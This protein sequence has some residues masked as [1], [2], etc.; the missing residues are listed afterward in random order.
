MKSWK[1]RLLTFGF[2]AGVAF[3]SFA[4]APQLTVLADDVKLEDENTSRWDG[5][6]TIL[7]DGTVRLESYTGKEGEVTIPTKLTLD[8]K[9]YKVV[10]LGAYC[11]NNN[12]TVT[13][14]FI[15]NGIVFSDTGVANGKTVTGGTNCFLGASNLS[16]M[17]LP[18]DMKQNLYEAG[19]GHSIITP[20]LK[21]YIVPRNAT[22]VVDSGWDKERWICGYPNTAADSIQSKVFVDISTAKYY[23]ADHMISRGNDGN[24]YYIDR[25]FGV[26][27]ANE[28]CR[29]GGEFY[30]IEDGVWQENVSEFA[31]YDGKLFRVSLGRI[32]TEANGLVNDPVNTMDWYYCY[33]GQVQDYSGLAEYDGAW[34]YVKDGLMD[35][36][37]RGYV[38]YDGGKFYVAAGR[39]LREVNG[40]AQDPE[41]G[42]WFYC[43]NGEAQLQYTGLAQYDGAWFYIEKGKLADKFNGYVW[44]DGKQFLVQNG[45]VVG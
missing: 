43:A 1:N 33:Q 10:S 5:T 15:P 8:G 2:T 7:D 42:E 40:L 3:G 35:T 36:T 9:D 18:N 31:Y 29:V 28:I 27:F 12:K 34:F 13:K 41:N 14:V 22:I 19:I 38:D 24:Y 25:Q 20:A 17:H 39:I 44:Y 23:D 26:E 32:D 16:R 30:V 37:M 6:Y 21:S 11:F 45:M 4:A